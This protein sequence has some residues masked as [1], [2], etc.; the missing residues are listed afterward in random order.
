MNTLIEYLSKRYRKNNSTNDD[1]G[2][3]KGVIKT[4]IRKQ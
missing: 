3:L 2:L 4:Q 1:I